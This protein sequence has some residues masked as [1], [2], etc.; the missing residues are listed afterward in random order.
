ML[1]I[2]RADTGEKPQNYAPDEYNTLCNAKKIQ[3]KQIA[4]VYCQ[5]A[6]CVL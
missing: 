6:G 1:L 2:M 4:S 3:T 5:T